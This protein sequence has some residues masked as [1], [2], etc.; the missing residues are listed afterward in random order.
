MATA[1]SADLRLDASEVMQESP[2]NHALRAGVQ[3]HVWVGGQER[4]AFLW[5]AHPVGSLGLWL[6]GRAR[7]APFQCD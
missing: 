5:Q 2:S 6:D 7:P 4:P 3:A 1:M